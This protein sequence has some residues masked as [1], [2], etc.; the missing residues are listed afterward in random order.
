VTDVMDL[1]IGYQ[2]HCWTLASLIVVKQ[3]SKADRKALETSTNVCTCFYPW[4]G[5]AA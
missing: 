5:H 3:L 4:F 2:R 1:K